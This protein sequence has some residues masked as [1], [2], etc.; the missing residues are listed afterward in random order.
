MYKIIILCIKNFELLFT[1]LGYIYR[2]I[3]NEFII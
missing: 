1:Y 3:N 2:E